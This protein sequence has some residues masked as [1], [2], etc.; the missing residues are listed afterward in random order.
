MGHEKGTV[1][2]RSRRCGWFDAALVRQTCVL[3]GVNGIALTKMDIVGPEL[4]DEW[5]AEVRKGLPEN[6][7]VVPISSVARRGLEA[8]NEALWAQIDRVR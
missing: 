1:T 8:L 6:I 4:A 2:G 7:E 5:V 3:S